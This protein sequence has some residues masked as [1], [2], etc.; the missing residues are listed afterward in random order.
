MGFI[1]ECILTEIFNFPFWTSS[2]PPN[3][4]NLHISSIQWQS[5]VHILMNSPPI[6]DFLSSSKIKI[7]DVDHSRMYFYPGLG[8][9][10][11][12]RSSRGKRGKRKRVNA[13]S[14]TMEHKQIKITSSQEIDNVKLTQVWNEPPWRAIQGY[15][16]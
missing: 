10:D 14:W 4:R 12:S 1:Q 6:W 8:F 13:A 15:I 9:W 11:M 3:M 2:A 5:T 16:N 7:T